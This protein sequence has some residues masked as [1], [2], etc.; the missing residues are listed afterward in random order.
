MTYL[1]NAWYAA[2]WDS[3]VVEGTVF[4][5]RI[6]GR[7]LVIFRKEDGQLGVLDGV[8]PHRFAPLARGRVIGDA[9]QCG[10]HGLTFDGTGTCIKSPFGSP[11]KTMSVRAYPVEERY[12]MIWVWPGDPELADPALV[13]DFSFQDPDRFYVGQGYLNVKAG[14]ELEIENILDLSHIEFLHADTLGSGKV[15][16]GKYEAKQAGEVVWSNR[17]VI[18]EVMTDQ[19]SI[20]MGFE[21][22][23]AVDRWIHVKWTAPANMAL[24]SGAVRTGRP[25]EEGNEFVGAHIFTPETEHS[26]H[27][28]YSS[29]IP[30]DLGP[31]GREIANRKVNYLKLPFETEDKLM[32]EDQQ[33]NIGN[34]TLGALKLGWLPGDAAGALARKILK[35]KIEA[36]RAT[37]SVPA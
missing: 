30:K 4:S 33:A 31:E 8:C 25:K 12:S 9:I 29:N 1:M 35:Q 7:P 20:N 5:R 28:W 32:L 21:P 13:P 18:G 22:G 34:R 15:S 23:T 16:T 36:E 2:A 26:S 11:P 24:Y 14:Y 3:E 17:D 19:L 10:Y 27:Y 6:L 37:L